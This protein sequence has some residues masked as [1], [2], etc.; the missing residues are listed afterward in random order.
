LGVSGQSSSSPKDLES[1]E[2]HNKKDIKAHKFILDS[3]NNNIIPHLSEKHTTKEIF[4]S[5]VG[6]FQSMNM[7]RKMMLRNRIRSM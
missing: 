4:Y 5:F 2:P 7:N 3:M 1:L 6:L